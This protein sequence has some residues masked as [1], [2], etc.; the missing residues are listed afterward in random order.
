M[1]KTFVHEAAEA[2]KRP[3]VQEM[4]RR[5][6]DY[7]LGVCVPHM[8]TEGTGEF[9]GLPHELVQSESQLQVS[10]VERS[11]LT[12]NDIPVAWRWYKELQVVETCKVC[13]PDGPHH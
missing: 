7:G 3:E 2:I 4:I 12:E 11:L 13:R 6:A 8:H 5:L 1:I 10:F 9:A